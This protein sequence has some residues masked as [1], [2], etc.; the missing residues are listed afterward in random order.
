M[1][2]ERS[3]L[4]RLLAAGGYPGFDKYIKQ[5]CEKCPKKPCNQRCGGVAALA[6]MGNYALSRSHFGGPEELNLFCKGLKEAA[7]VVG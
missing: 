4:D 5:I 6:F 7:E 1:G 3:S 2:E